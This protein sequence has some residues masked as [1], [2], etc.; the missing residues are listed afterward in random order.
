[1]VAQRTSASE[2]AYIELRERILHGHFSPG[3]KL[4]VR[5]L[6]EELDLSPTP[7]KTALAAL[8]KEGLIRVVPNRGYF[9][10][11][12]DA[13]EV[14]EIC[15]VRGVLDRLAAELAASKPDHTDLAK[16]LERNL[17]AQRYAV[18]IGR[19]EEYADLNHEFHRMI[20]ESCGNRRV[21][22]FSNS[23]A[24]QVRLLVNSSARVHGR[25]GRSL[26]EHEAIV[27]A[28]RAGDGPNAGAQ[29][30]THVLNSEDTLLEVLAQYGESEPDRTA[31]LIPM[32]GIT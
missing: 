29:A 11:T 18:E 2:Y 20:S 31:L 6:T 26:D 1:M 12:F 23:I 30:L 25:P 15:V 9:V 4:V 3:A 10:E 27:K 7:V 19:T 5:P 8:E 17:E 28:V 24:G 13:A 14:R 16:R 32:P 22:I 21:A